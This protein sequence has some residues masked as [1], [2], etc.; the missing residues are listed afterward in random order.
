MAYENVFCN[1]PWY[2]L[3]IFWDGSFGYCCA[4]TPHR[5]YSGYLTSV[6]NIKVMSISDWHNSTPMKSARMSMDSEIK[7][8]E[9][10]SCWYQEKF[11]TTSRR[12]KSNIKSAIF[13]QSFDISLIQSPSYNGFKY[14]F[15]NNGLTNQLPVDLH[16]DLGNYCNLACKFCCPEASSKIAR[17]YSK[18]NILEDDNTIAS[19][20]TRDDDVWDRFIEQVIS[21][22]DLQNIHFMGGETLITPRFEDFIDKLIE[23]KRY[24]V[25]ISF[26]S[27]GTSYNPR[28]MKKLSKFERV[29]IEVS[30]ETLTK[31]NEYIR[32]G[33]KNEV[34]IGNIEKYIELSLKSSID[35]T[36]RP[37]V[38]LLSIGYYYT[39]LQFCLDNKLLLKSNNVIREVGWKS[40]KC[41]DVR[42]LPREVKVEY[43]K[44]YTELLRNID[45][46]HLIDDFNESDSHNYKTVIKN[47]CV[48]CISLLEEEYEHNLYPDLVEL[49]EKWD[50]VY[51][52][53]ANDLYPEL[54]EML[55]KNNYNVS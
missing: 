24:E 31:H 12:H 5:P 30:I 35:I 14:S 27:N 36:V 48:K 42:V 11:S 34:V 25:C 52:F 1:S 40:S 32:Q 18:W 43:K 50:K 15:D 38:S 3:H 9:C 19:D 17:Q 41:M 33:T 49:L 53:N 39:L 51:D 44:N 29:G 7:I 28:L 4:Q 47:E 8:P 10:D 20:W 16:I 55:S 54:R 45:D 13:K 26:V 6:Y 2:E 46:E 37:A 21:I 23:Y 22:K